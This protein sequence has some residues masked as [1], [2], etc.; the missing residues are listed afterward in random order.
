MCVL[1]CLLR[2]QYPFC[3]QA[4][5]S[6]AWLH[7]HA[8]LEALEPGWTYLFEAIYDINRVVVPHAFEGL[9]LLGA[10]SPEGA[11]ASPQARASLSARLGIMSVSSLMG[12]PEELLLNL[13]GVAILPPE[14]RQYY[15][16]QWSTSAQ[17]STP[18]FEGWVL[19]LSDGTHEKLVQAAY[20]RV[21]LA[22]KAMHPLAV[23][24]A[25][26]TGGQSW[27]DL[28]R[29]LP[30]HLSS[31]MLAILEA[32]EGAFFRA[33]DDLSRLMK[34][35]QDCSP[36]DLEKQVS[37]VCWLAQ[38]LLVFEFLNPG[39]VVGSAN[40]FCSSFFIF[41]ADSC[42][43]WAGSKFFRRPDCSCWGGERDWQG[44]SRLGRHTRRSPPPSPSLCSPH[45]GVEVDP[46]ETQR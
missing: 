46:R 16:V 15:R 41:C 32:L 7:A 10:V 14:E 26:R 36:G 22:A 27:D 17:W 3:S 30:P 19:T 11:A 40:N 18:L 37:Q 44:G 8:D 6:K 12:T 43:K 31:E 4:I 29:G 1:L 5:W 42:F 45:G 20:K 38:S 34:E 35:Q 21:A 24:D 13:P 33:R 25:V 23:W 9:V 39:C 2:R 28:V